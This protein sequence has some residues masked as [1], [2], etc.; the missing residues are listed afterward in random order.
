MRG[1]TRGRGRADGLYW[2]AR[3]AG[4]LG[5]V[6]LPGAGLL[7]VLAGRRAEGQ[8]GARLSPLVSSRF[9]PGAGGD[10]RLMPR[11]P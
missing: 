3:A 4:L 6:R 10:T 9:A 5:S 8:R 2:R 11:A 1:G 7:R